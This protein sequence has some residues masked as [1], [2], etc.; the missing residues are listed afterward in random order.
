[1]GVK[2]TRHQDPIWRESIDRRVRDFL[3]RGLDDVP[4]CTPRQRNIYR[5][6]EGVRP[7][8]LF[9]SPRTREERPLMRGDVENARI[10]PKDGLSSVAVV[11]VPVDDQHP[12]APRGQRRRAH[13]N[14]IQKAEAHCAI[15]FGV[16]AGGSN[17]HEGNSLTQ[18][19]QSSDRFK[20]GPGGSSGRP[21]RVGS[22]VRIG[23]DFS[24][25]LLAK[26]FEFLEVFGRVDPAQGVA[27]RFGGAD[28]CHGIFKVEV[29]HS[30][31]Y[32][33]DSALLFRVERP[34]IVSARP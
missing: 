32:R 26:V 14:V 19:L 29:T 31:H 18:Y 7:S 4:G 22:G 13:S 16:M 1:M 11:D 28:I 24:A 23:I 9:G 5:E 34:S 20:A 2:P 17:R 12:V 10:I 6:T 15:G 8:G 3:E 33:E 30:I 21:E 27:F 25:A